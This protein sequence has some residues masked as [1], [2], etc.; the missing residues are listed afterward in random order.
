[1]ALAHNGILRG[2]NS[3]Y[4]QATHIPREDPDAIQDFLIYCQS[5]CESMHHHHDAEEK[6]FF[7]SIEQISNVRGIMERNIEQHRAF[8]PGFDLFQ[9]DSQTCLPEAYDG[10]KIRT[11]IEAFA[12]P[13]S[14]HL[15][16]EIETLRA[17]DMYDSGRIRQAYQRLEKI[18]MATDNVRSTLMYASSLT[19]LTPS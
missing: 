5:W 10:Q 1:M 17:L 13:L 9:E 14:R 4:L 7:P 16:D 2:L 19:S 6:D 8:T 15:H 18:L 12:E 11:L 3:I